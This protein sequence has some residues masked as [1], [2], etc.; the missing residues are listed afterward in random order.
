[1]GG[2]KGKEKTT[3]NI[4]LCRM[5][6]SDFSHIISFTGQG[7]CRDNSGENL[8][9]TVFFIRKAKGCWS[10]VLAVVAVYVCVCGYADRSGL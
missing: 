10:H 2:G 8:E 1:M 3:Q 4:L 5:S 7:C 9:D 6:K